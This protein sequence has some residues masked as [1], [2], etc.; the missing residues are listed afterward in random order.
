[1]CY[2]KEISIYT[3][4]IGLV[5]SYLLLKNDK[6]TLKIIGSFFLVVIHMQLIDF[7]LWSNNKCN[8]TNIQISTV[9]AVLNFIQ[10][11]VLY[12]AIIYYNKNITNEN[13][14]ILNIIILIY[15][16]CLLIY[17]INLFPLGCSVV[18]KL[19]Y[20]YLNWSW[21][22]DKISKLLYI[23][24]PIIL[25]L[26]IYFGLDKPYNLYLS[27]ICIISF[28]ISF[29]IYKQKKIIGSMWCWFSALMPLGILVVDKFFPNLKQ[30]KI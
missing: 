6:P 20:P 12:L 14:K 18:T 21:F 25:I 17:C 28:I 29:I 3:Y 5:S 9:G 22:K 26:L 11:I 23:I 10:P 8:N 15:I 19:S 24:F 16:V 1:M 7:F 27:L 30:I 2:N 4:I 13:K